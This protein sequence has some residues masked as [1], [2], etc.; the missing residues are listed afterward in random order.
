MISKIKESLQHLAVSNI[1]LYTFVR[2]IAG[3]LPFLLPH[4]SAFYAFKKIGDGDRTFL[5]IGANDGIS[6]RSFRKLVPNRP[7][8]SFE[9]NPHHEKSLNQVKNSI[10]NF[11]FQLSGVGEEN[12]SLTLY[13]PIYNNIPLTNYASLDQDAARMNLSNH[14]NIDGIGEK[15]EFS[16]HEV[17][18]IKLD[19]LNLDPA[20]VKIDVEGFEDI[21]IK[22][23]LETIKK[24]LPLIMVEYNG[25]SFVAIKS[26]LQEMHY[27]ACSYDPENDSFASFDESTPCLN[28]F[29]VPAQSELYSEG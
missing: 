21:V 28:A 25:R 18:I 23:M 13:T 27:Y 29:F 12:G 5:D 11:N 24:S 20:I 4:D 9:P 26:M 15:V 6:A 3:K 7:I 19:E 22:G 16:K 10:K 8:L 17:R 1:Y 2:R 14:M